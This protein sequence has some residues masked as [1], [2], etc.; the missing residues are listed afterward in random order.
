MFLTDEDNESERLRKA[1]TFRSFYCIFNKRKARV[2][3]G[4]L[5]DKLVSLGSSAQAF[6]RWNNE[7]RKNP[8]ADRPRTE[9][10]E[11]QTESE[12]LFIFVRT[13]SMSA[14]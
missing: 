8:D 1:V 3:R 13:F 4:E 14:C 7:S 11:A 12:R 6:L 5:H 2:T 10:V 9:E